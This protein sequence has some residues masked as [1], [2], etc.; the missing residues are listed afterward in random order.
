MADGLRYDAVV[1]GG[2]GYNGSLSSG[3][4]VSGNREDISRLSDL[5]ATGRV[6]YLGRFFV[7]GRTKRATAPGGV[8]GMCGAR[9]RERISAYSRR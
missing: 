5:M 1:V 8:I 4:Y 7:D 6:A 2:G 3:R 9:I